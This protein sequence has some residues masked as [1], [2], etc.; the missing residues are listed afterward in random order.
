MHSDKV[1]EVEV[2]REEYLDPSSSSPSHPYNLSYLNIFSNQVMVLGDLGRRLNTALAELSKV[3][4]VNDAAIDTLLRSITLALLESDVNVKLV[5]KLRD[6]VRKQVREA[7]N[8]PK[9]EKLNKAQRRSLVQKAIYDHLVALVDPGVEPYKPK[10][11]KPN[12][13]M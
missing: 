5:S 6:D 13:I 2:V 10:K 11:G 12:V 7:L 8:D 9:N 1:V 3:P 4:T